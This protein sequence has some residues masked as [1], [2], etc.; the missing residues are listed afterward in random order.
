MNKQAFLFPGQGSQIIGMGNDL[1]KTDKH[2]NELVEFASDYTNEDLQ[3][4]C[5]RGPEK[6]LIKSRFLQP[7]LCSVSL[8]YLRKLREKNIVPDYVLGHSLGEITA[9]AA[10]GIIPDQLAV[11][12]AAKRGILMDEA[13]AQ[14]D[15]T[16]MAVLFIPIQTVEEILDELNEPDCI[17]LANDNAPNQIVLSGSRLMLEKFEQRVTQ[18]RLG[19][20]RKIVVSGPWHSQFLVSARKQFAIWAKDIPFDPPSHK[21]IFNATAQLESQPE[22]I[23][24]LITWQLTKPVYWR[25]CMESL[26]K[27]KV[28]TFFEIGSGRVLS[29]LIRVNGYPRSTTVFNINN[30]KGVESAATYLNS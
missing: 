16:M 24:E 10:A 2:F 7:L 15:G 18:N 23:K 27:F 25:Q 12:I 28:D 1:F 21:M 29:G 22:K 19:K 4:L 20:C 26:K 13:A 6:R 9:L 3:S 17:A 8:G 14:C 5:L 11:K 30:L